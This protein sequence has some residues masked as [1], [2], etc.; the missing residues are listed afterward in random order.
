M[1]PYGIPRRRQFVKHL[2]LCRGRSRPERWFHDLLCSRFSYSVEPLELH[3][4]EHASS[5]GDGSSQ[6][7]LAQEVEDLQRR[8]L[9]RLSAPEILCD[10]L[11]KYVKQH[12]QLQK[13]GTHSI[14]CMSPKSENGTVVLR[15]VR[16]CNDKVVKP[17]SA[18]RQSTRIFVCVLIIFYD[19]FCGCFSKNAKHLRHVGKYFFRFRVWRGGA[20]C[21][22]LRLR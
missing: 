7:R 5:P 8:Q 22:M 2:Y 13:S 21:T 10:C 14:V 15:F 3:S 9:A 1:R 12:E 18:T 4:G 6:Q 11:Q 20:V 17:L 16:T 19:L